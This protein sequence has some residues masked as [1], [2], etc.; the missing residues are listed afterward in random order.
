MRKIDAFFL[1]HPYYGV[2]RMTDSLN[3]DLGYC[4]NVK[5]TRRLYRLMGLQTIYKKPRTTVRDLK[6]YKYP[7]L[8]KDL[9]IVRPNQ[10]WQTDITYIPRARGFMYMYAIIDVHSSK[11]L[12][13]SISNSIDKESVYRTT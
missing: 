4:I 8:L 6:S 12:N 5:R 1:E 3:L 11:I 9:K 2:A 10:V 7:Y 13:W